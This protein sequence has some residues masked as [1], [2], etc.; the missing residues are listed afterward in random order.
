LY[1]DEPQRRRALF[2]NLRSFWRFGGIGASEE[3]R[4]RR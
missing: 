2:A 4:V 3:G 1:A